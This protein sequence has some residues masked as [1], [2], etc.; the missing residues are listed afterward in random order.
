MTHPIYIAQA[1]YQVNADA[2]HGEYVQI[3]GE[4]YYKIANY[5]QMPPFFMSIVSDADHWLFISST[6]GLSAGRKNA[7]SALFPYYTED[8]LTES[9]EHTGSKTL[10]RIERGGSAFGWEP[11]STRYAGIYRLQRNLYKNVIGNCVIFEEINLDLQIAFSYAWQTS[12]RFG[13]AR[14]ATLANRGGDACR[15][16]L[17]DGVQNILPYGTTALMQNTFSV[18]MDAYKRNELDAEAGLGMFTLSSTLTD[19]AEPSESLKATTVWQMGLP[20]PTYL[21]SSRQ[22]DA[23]RA[24]AELVAETD[25]RGVKGAFFAHAAVEVAASADIS[26][27]IVADVNQDHAQVIALSRALRQNPQETR[28]QVEADIAQG[29]ANLQ[30]IIAR[31]DGMQLS[32]DHLC[33]THHVANVLFNTMRGGIFA[34]GYA[35][36]AADLRDFIHARN[37]QVLA[38]QADFFDSLPETLALSDLLQRAASSGSAD[39]ERL[40]YEYLPLTFSRR[41]GD[42]SRPWNQFSINVKKPDGSKNLD[43]QGNWRDIFQ[44]WEPLALAYPACS[45]S[46]IAKFLNAAT[47]DGY[48]PYRITRQGIEWEIPEPHNPWANIGYWGDHQIIYL[49]KLLEVSA[50]F[51]PGALERLLERRIFSHANVPYRIKPYHDLIADCYH[52]IDFDAA[53]DEATRAQVKAFGT[54]GKLRLTADRRVA[55]VNGMEKLLILLL[56]KLS[57]FVPGGGIWMNTQRPEWNDGNNALVGKGVSMVTLCYLRRFIAFQRDVLARCSQAQFAVSQGVSSFLQAIAATLNAHAPRLERNDLDDRARRVM[58]DELGEAGSAYRAQC[59]RADG[60]GEP[61]NVSSAELLDLLTVALRVVDATI[62][63]NRRPDGLYHAYNILTFGADTA[64]V[65]HLYEMLEGQVAALSSGLL[66]ASES[67]DVLRALRSSRM[68]RADQHSYMLYPDRD[69]PG[70]LAKNRLDAARV[71]DSELVAALTARGNRSVLSQDVD[72]AYHFC[73][74]FRNVRDLK[75]A[76][77]ALRAD[78][79]YANLVEREAEAICQLFEEVFN[80]RAF[81]GR[82]GTFFGYEG[83]GSIYWHMVS[84]LLLATQETYCRAAANG[85]NPASLQELAERYYDIRSG[86]S[87]NKPPDVY[88]AFPTDPYSHTPGGKGAKQPGMT[89]QVKEEILTRL[90]ELGLFVNAGRITFSPTLLRQS[91]FLA[92]AQTFRYVD[93]AGQTRELALPAGS[94]AYT[95]CQVP[96]ACR[97][98]SAP[99]ITVTFRDGRTQTIDG[100]SLDADLS[101]QIFQRT[102]QIAHIAVACEEATFLKEM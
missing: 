56:T 70:F 42:P 64:V 32:A 51:H 22:L 73:G 50:Q 18:L 23:F 17:L 95:F 66:S 21:L 86:L 14:T 53:L 69:L 67:L 100:G 57:N 88:G 2:V 19:L 60:L 76:L 62:R 9:A 91:E 90:G 75:A 79:R 99:Q 8:K 31:A 46:L 96:I 24:G 74:D 39:V 4:D 10:L 6:G 3:G 28:A 71:K 43:Y 85:E 26:W 82:S 89:G 72:G 84:K 12:D 5:D 92:Q 81:T 68:Y 83:L 49:Q 44:N 97:A 58:M 30:A 20:T 33:A 34:D 25:L 16:V 41:H 48:N 93:V 102:G 98:A 1:R 77:N 63:A 36:C 11:F 52:T 78:A 80:H 27:Q 94:L 37:R 40:C 55:H 38:E 7:D 45:E 29:R 87:F 65:E 35:I 59:Y 54:D 13:F 15:I 61:V 101:E 47:A